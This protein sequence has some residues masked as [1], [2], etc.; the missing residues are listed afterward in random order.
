[1]RQRLLLDGIV[2]PVDLPSKSATSKCIRED[3]I[4]TKKKIQQV[5][6]EAKT[7]IN[8]EHT[9]FFLDQ[10]SDLPPTSIHFFDESSVVKTTMNRRYGNA[11]LGEP[12]FEVQRYASNANFTINLLQSM[13]GVDYVNVIEGAS[14]GNELLLFFEEALNITKADG[15][16]VLERGDTVVMDNCGFHHSHFTEPV[17]RDMLEECGVNLLFQPPYSPHFNTCEFCFRQIKAFLN[18]HQELAEN[19]RV[20]YFFRM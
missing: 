3:L 15:S 6:L 13:Q 14:N 4:M 18:R 11:P 1:M 17:L 10:I 8:V 9:D 12:A 16:V 19:Q 5:P 2:Y 7:T 20:F